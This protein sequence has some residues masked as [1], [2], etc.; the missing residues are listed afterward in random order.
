MYFESLN[1]LWHMAGHGV[2]VWSAYAISLVVLV[3]LVYYPYRQYREQ[4]EA[5]RKLGATLNEP[6]QE[7]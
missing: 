1:E 4:L 6:S 2:F 3:G 5:I 7:S